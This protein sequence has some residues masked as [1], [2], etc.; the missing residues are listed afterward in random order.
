MLTLISAILLFYKSYYLFAAQGK[1]A[2]MPQGAVWPL[3]ANAHCLGAQGFHT[4]IIAKL[5]KIIIIYLL[6]TM[7]C[8]ENS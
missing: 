4:Q 6:V 8:K 3:L 1:S 7:S 5:N 2:C